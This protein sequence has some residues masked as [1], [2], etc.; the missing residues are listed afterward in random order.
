MSRGFEGLIVLAATLAGGSFGILAG[1]VLDHEGFFGSRDA[2]A[3]AVEGGLFGA[4]MVAI[5]LWF[6]QRTNAGSD[7][8]D[9]V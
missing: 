1:I 7:V 5:V 8:E 4:V 2:L 6:M 9:G 3:H